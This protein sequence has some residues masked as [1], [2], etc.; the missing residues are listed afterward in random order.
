[1]EFWKSDNPAVRFQENVTSP[2]ATSQSW[3][4][5]C[6]SLNPL[7]DDD[8]VEIASTTVTKYM[9][10]MEESGQIRGLTTK[11]WPYTWVIAGVRVLNGRTGG[12]LS[13]T[14]RFQTLEGGSYN[15]F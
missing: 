13:E 9:P 2:V 14:V 4:K 8:E 1:M 3:L 7:S 12:E 11:L 15:N 5:Y 6:P 10:M